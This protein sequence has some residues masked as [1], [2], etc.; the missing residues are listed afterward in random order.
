MPVVGTEMIL[1]LMLC[2]GFQKLFDS[3]ILNFTPALVCHSA[4]DR[5]EQTALD[6]LEQIGI[7]HF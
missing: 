2:F 3:K 6:N 7:Q 1:N 4:D 5:L